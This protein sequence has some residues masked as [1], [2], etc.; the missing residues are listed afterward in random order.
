MSQSRYI[1]IYEYKRPDFAKNLKSRERI[2]KKLVNNKIYPTEK[3]YNEWC[4]F[5]DMWDFYYTLCSIA[6]SEYTNDE[7]W[8]SEINYF[9]DHSIEL[10]QKDK[11]ITKAFLQRGRLGDLTRY[12]GNL[13]VK[14][15][16]SKIHN[17]EKIAL[18]SAEYRSVQD[19]INYK[20]SLKFTFN[21]KRTD[22]HGIFDNLLSPQREIR[23]EAYKIIHESFSTDLIDN[24][25]NRL[26]HIRDEISKS[27]SYENYEEFIE[28]DSFRDW[29]S[30]EAENFKSAIKKYIVPI[31]NSLQ[32]SKK[33]RLTIS[34]LED[35]DEYIFWRGG[36][37]K[38]T[39]PKK[40]LL[41]NSLIIIESIFGEDISQI[42]Y[43]MIEN[44]L[45]DTERRKNKNVGAYCYFIDGTNDSF[46]STNFINM[47]DEPEAFFHEFGHALQFY[48]SGD[49]TI[50]ELRKPSRELLEIP[51][52][53][54]E[55]FAQDYF[56]TFYGQKER[57]KRE[58]HLI[59]LL[60]LIC[61]VCILDDWQ[62][63]LYR[64][65]NWTKKERNKCWANAEKQWTPWRNINPERWK[66]DYTVFESPFY[67]L[68]YG[69]ATICAL[70]LWI[71]SKTNKE[72]AIKKY[73]LLC[74]LGGKKNLQDTLKSTKIKNPFE[75]E[76]IKWISEQ[77]KII[78]K[79]Y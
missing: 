5:K 66:Q 3:L 26:V 53:T 70:Q 28:E 45:I 55:L 29:G 18:E 7:F 25:M 49:N 59:N 74:E 30:K 23:K 38:L 34:K 35:W 14:R 13:A 77:L 63:N 44:G 58:L 68:D 33:R 6:L 22:I 52:I 12:I 76:T 36:N 4:K 60:V 65:P 17:N 46:I 73:L 67:D 57:E 50:H 39:I 42:A 9:S 1:G 62:R 20:D 64:N 56:E 8:I 31:I 48:F 2:L 78:L 11:E 40:S 69:I 43:D 47:D 51:S 27:C 21:G 32:K 41:K 15:L 72:S 19:W 79:D 71:E 16:R 61:K 24:I 37:P 10:N 75:E 54:L